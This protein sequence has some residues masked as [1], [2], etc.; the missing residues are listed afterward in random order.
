[1]KSLVRRFLVVLLVTLALRGD[2]AEEK[3]PYEVFGK[4]VQGYVAF[5][6]SSEM[7]ELVVIGEPRRL[8][9]EEADKLAELLNS[10]STWYK[11][12]PSGELMGMAKFC[13]PVWDFKFLL[14]GYDGQPVVSMRF[15]SS[16][17]Q[18]SVTADYAR[19]ELPAMLEPGTEPLFKMLDGWFP[20]WR[21][22]TKQNRAEWSKR[23]KA[24]QRKKPATK[25]A[26][27]PAP[28]GVQNRP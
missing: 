14:T 13:L 28:E 27:K 22:R 1:M 21:T 9:S 18:V 23:P 20:D 5:C 19:V 4:V 10:E 15:C 3:P 17:S 11:R 7:D 8:S 24:E 16:C 26:A 6:R 2:A 25:E 12:R